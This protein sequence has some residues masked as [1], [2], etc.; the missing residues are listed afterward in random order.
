MKH[1][2]C[3]LSIVPIRKEN[4]NQSEL[5][6]QLLYG[7]CFKI[8]STKKDWIQIMTLQDEYSGWI[9]KKQF[10]VISEKEAKNISLNTMQYSN[11]LVDFIET[12]N[13]SL[14]SIVMGS[15]ILLEEDNVHQIR[16]LPLKQNFRIMMLFQL[17]L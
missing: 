7:D 13:Q 2:I 15:N 12:E 5:V 9:D 8:I 6:S 3:H 1:G 16:F 4:S 14:V 11:Q 17:L 10:Q